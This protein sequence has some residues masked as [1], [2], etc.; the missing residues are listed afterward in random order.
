MTIQSR[1]QAGRGSG[2]DQGLGKPKQNVLSDTIRAILRDIPSRTAAGA[3]AVMLVVTLCISVLLDYRYQRIVLEDAIERTSIIMWQLVDLSGLAPG[4][5]NADVTSQ[6]NA[7]F[8]SSIH[9][10]NFAAYAES[11]G[12]VRWKTAMFEGNEYDESYFENDRRLRGSGIGLQRSLGVPEG[13]NFELIDDQKPWDRMYRLTYRFGGAYRFGGDRQQAYTFRL[14][15]DRDPYAQRIAEYRA[16]SFALSLVAL[17]I[18]GSATFFIT[19][20]QVAPLDQLATEVRSIEQRGEGYRVSEKDS[21]PDEIRVL[22]RQI[23][24]HLAEVQA[25]KEESAR[26][27]ESTITRLRKTLENVRA[28]ERGNRHA[29]NS[30]LDIASSLNFE[31][32]SE[33]EERAWQIVEGDLRDLVNKELEIAGVRRRLQK[34][35]ESVGVTETL[36]QMK[37]LM[38]SWFSRKVYDV[39]GPELAIWVDPSDLKEILGNLL[40]NAGKYGGNRIQATVEEADGNVRIAIEDDGDGFPK[41]ALH[42]LTEW[43]FQANPDASGHGYGLAYVKEMVTLYGGDLQLEDST[44]LGGAS[45]VLLFPSR[46]PNGSS[47]SRNG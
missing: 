40:S 22:S 23:N 14:F 33:R 27:Y 28:G 30:L 11:Q 10:G 45:A 46:R 16:T 47:A 26:A 5:P 8:I 34:L 18:V 21:D 38:A 43:G 35:K 6:T 41:E 32:P 3:T 42:R 31:F 13:F 29:I 9:Y 4:P 20:R 15:V 25:R 1:K 2:H 24:Q 44:V 37:L 36:T 17:V 7:A 19:R 39:S 12:T